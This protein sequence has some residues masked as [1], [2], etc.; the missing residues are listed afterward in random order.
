[1]QGRLRVALAGNVMVL[2]Q[3]MLG[4]LLESLYTIL[5]KICIA[6]SGNHRAKLSVAFFFFT[7]PGYFR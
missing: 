4:S 5:G 1:M 7:D 6:P 3:T 2:V